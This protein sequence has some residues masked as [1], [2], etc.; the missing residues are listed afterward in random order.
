MRKSKTGTGIGSPLASLRSPAPVIQ[1]GYVRNAMLQQQRLEYLPQRLPH[2]YKE[3]SLSR[4]STVWIILKNEESNWWCGSIIHYMIRPHLRNE[5]WSIWNYTL[6]T[7]QTL[8][9]RS[10]VS[11]YVGQKQYMPLEAQS[12]YMY[13]QNTALQLRGADAFVPYISVKLVLVV[14]ERSLEVGIIAPRLSDPTEGF[15]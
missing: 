13:V 8:Q 5:G 9:T 7:V 12:P 2:H 11:S 10:S 6:M 4:I 1:L 15:Y 3:N 14:Q